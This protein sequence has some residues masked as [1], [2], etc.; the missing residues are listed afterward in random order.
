MVIDDESRA[1]YHVCS[2]PAS[3]PEY[4]TTD[5][6]PACHLWRLL[7]APDDRAPAGRNGTPQHAWGTQQFCT[8]AGCEVCP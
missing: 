1:V 8:V 7:T 6:C 3:H 2:L 4:R 5:Y